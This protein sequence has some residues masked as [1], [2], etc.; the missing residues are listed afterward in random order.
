MQSS[1]KTILVA[2]GAL[3]FLFGPFSS[4]QAETS[5]PTIPRTLIYVTDSAKAMVSL[6]AHVES[7][8]IVAPQTYAATPEGALLGKPKEEILT[9]AKNAGAE[10]MP[11]VVNRY[12]SQSGVDAFL[13]SDAA[14]QR[15]V[16]AMVAE[17]K[18][19][20]YIGFQYDFEH[21]PAADR[22]LYSVF[23]ARSATVFHSVGL[24]LSVAVA[25]E[26]SDLASDYG[27]GSYA[28]WTGAFDYRALGVSAD[29]VSVMAYD[30]SRS[31]GPA[32]ALPWVRQVLTYTLAHIPAEKVSLGIPF[33][34]WVWRDKT[35][36][37][38]YSRTYSA[39]AEVLK[40]RSAIVT[41]GFSD[42]LGVPYVT[43][44]KQKKRYTAWYEDQ[45]S[46]QEKLSLVTDNK[47]YGFSAWA[48]GQ[49]DPAIWQ[50]V[51]LLQ[52]PRS[53]LAER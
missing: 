33:Y 41:K 3:F 45:K 43:Y 12:F 2:A 31:V 27:P 11:L 13:R 22:D 46:F 8:D 21:I 29:F 39:I 35:G 42:T 19:K 51:A 52:V 16:S 14:E 28:N 30:D 17:A 50:N 15:L 20:G 53:T 48:L 6:R 44:V 47:L 10:V 26:H 24:K 23:V 1:Y 32:A 4:V 40:T 37:R 36:E 5:S 7:M 34:A 9:L 18:N 49:E 38:E 25:P